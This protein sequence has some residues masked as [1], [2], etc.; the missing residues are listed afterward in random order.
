MSAELVARPVR[1]AF[2]LPAIIGLH[3]GAF[4]VVRLGLL[5]QLGMPAIEAPPVVT[6][7]EPP[8]PTTVVRPDDF[9]A[10][11]FEGE[12][13]MKPDVIIPT[14]D[15][16]LQASFVDSRPNPGG[17]GSAPQDQSTATQPPRLRTHGGGVQSLID[18]CYPAASRRLSE[19]GRVVASVLVGAD[20]R[21]AA[22]AVDERSGFPRLDAAMD[23]VLRRL[24]FVAGRRDGRAVEATARVPI[25][26]RLD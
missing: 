21:A 22:W 1:Q 13:Q 8:T 10:G 18:S 23:C 14:F 17:A 12:I 6:N 3:L 19:E 4:A 26:F 5:P 16:A 15:Q 24:E 20:G 25:V 2:V 9:D 7:L 11:Y